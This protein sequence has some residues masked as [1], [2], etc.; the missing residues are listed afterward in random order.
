MEAEIAATAKR[1]ANG[2]PLANRWHKAFIRRL[3]DPA[4]VTEAELDE[5]YRFLE[6]GDYAEGLAA[7]REKRRPVFKAE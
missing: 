7:F 2:A 4:P 3:D 5:C 1:I 6:T